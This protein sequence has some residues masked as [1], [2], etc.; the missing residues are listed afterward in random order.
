MMKNPKVSHLQ[1]EL[2]RKKT[3]YFINK[4]VT[5]FYGSD[6]I[7]LW[8]AKNKNRTIF[9]LVTMSDLAYTV[10]VIKNGH[11]I[12]EQLN[13]NRNS[14]GEGGLQGW[15]EEEF[16]TSTKKTPKF[17]KKAGKKREYNT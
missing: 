9:D 7:T 17:M 13:E 5:G 12:W 15:G 14:S 1:D 3:C 6:H 10:A 16:K 11:E 8:A 4:Y 2:N